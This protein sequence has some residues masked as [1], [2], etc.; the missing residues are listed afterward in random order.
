MHKVLLVDDEVFVRKGLCNL[1]EWEEL[2]FVVAGEAENGEDALKQIIDMQPDLVI[3]DIRMPLM[4]GLELIRRAVEIPGL[5][6]S[7]I[8]ISGYNDFAYAKQAIQFGVLDYILKPID[9]AELRSTLQKL[10]CTLSRKKLTQ[11]AREQQLADSVMEALIHGTADEDAVAAVASALDVK[12]DGEYCYVV[13]EVYDRAVGYKEIAA[14]VKAVCKANCDTENDARMPRDTDRFVPV[15]EQSDGRY[16]LLLALPPAQAGAGLTRSAADQLLDDRLGGLA[17]GLTQ[18]LGTPVA[19]FAGLTVNGLFNIRRSYQT[20][21]ETVKHKYA[22][23]QRPYIHYKEISG[24]PLHERMLSDAFYDR[25]MEQLEENNAEGCRDAVRSMFDSF[26]KDRLDP[27]AVWSAIHRGMIAIIRVI[28]EMDGNAQQLASF[29]AVKDWEH[30]SMGAREL[31]ELF[32][33]FVAEAA[34]CISL[35]RQEQSK[36]GIEKIRKYIETNYSDNIS[37]KTIAAHFYMNPVYLGQLFRKTYGVYFNDF[38]LSLR[39]G[40]AKK[41]LRLTDMRMYEIASKVGFQNADYFVAQFV[42]QE[43]MTPKEYRNKLI[44]KA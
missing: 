15:Y 23:E 39:M 18:A 19:L 16:G 10:A 20:A 17:K 12:M 8:L 38:L 28:Q 43:G 41:L 1:I 3:T 30:R 26:R 36:G 6:P 2:G 31:E 9:D 22:E 42:K 5:D 27:S 33:G 32:Q 4:D 40:E 7:F 37:L 35:L 24:K 13:I 44:Q 11:N 25:L 29:Q 14:A 21:A 34:E